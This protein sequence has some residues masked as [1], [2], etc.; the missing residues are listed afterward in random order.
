MLLFLFRFIYEVTTSQFSHTYQ[1]VD[2]SDK[3]TVM[4]IRTKEVFLSVVQLAPQNCTLKYLIITTFYQVN[5][6]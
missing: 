6:S 2:M 3:V 5:S 4:M 1:D